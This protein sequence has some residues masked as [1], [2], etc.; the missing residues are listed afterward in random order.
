M[1][2]SGSEPN[3][4]GRRIRHPVPDV[5]V[6][7]IKQTLDRA[8]DMG[9]S[10]LTARQALDSLARENYELRGRRPARDD[11]EPHAPRQNAD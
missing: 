7:A 11:P 6:D 1:N 3:E 4:E 10:T 9:L 2:R 5:R 8:T